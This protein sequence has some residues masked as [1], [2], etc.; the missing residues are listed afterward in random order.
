MNERVFDLL[1]AD[2][3]L[4]DQHVQI[5]KVLMHGNFAA[6]DV[7]Q[8]TNLPMGRIYGYLNDLV[9]WQLIEKRF[10]PSMYSAENLDQRVTDF[11]DRQYQLLNRKRESLLEE[12]SLPEKVEIF[13]NVDE[14]KDKF[15]GFLKDSTFSYYVDVGT[16]VPLIFLPRKEVEAVR[17]IRA[18]YPNYHYTEARH[19][20]RERFWKNLDRLPNEK[21]IIT[22]DCATNYFNA[23]RRAFG[24]AYLINRLQDIFRYMKQYNI[25]LRVKVGLVANRSVITDKRFISLFYLEDQFIALKVESK[26]LVNAYMSVFE[27]VFESSISLDDFVRQELKLPAFESGQKAVASRQR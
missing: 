21:H 15:Y 22:M 4:K 9:S 27:N 2:F 5:L 25:E 8:K 26:A 20:N 14:F 6:E 16:A 11:L 17:V 18:F 24:E 1:K 7:A 13:T 3:D 10:H 23:V 19:R 12:L